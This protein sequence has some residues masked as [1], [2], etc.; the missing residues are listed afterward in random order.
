M[1]NNE[2]L[3]QFLRDTSGDLLVEEKEEKRRNGDEYIHA[4]QNY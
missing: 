4:P 2:E 3:C 1:K